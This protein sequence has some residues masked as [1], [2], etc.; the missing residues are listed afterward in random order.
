[1][2]PTPGANA[3]GASTREVKRAM[4]AIGLYGYLILPLALLV[5]GCAAASPAA[6]PTAAPVQKPPTAPTAKPAATAVP[7]PAATPVPLP[8]PQA[9]GNAA[10][11]WDESGRYFKGNPAAKVVLEEWTS[12]Q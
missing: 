11:Q 2:W 9:V 12:I 4:R 8:T 7:G 1:M 10:R 6:T 5:V 3:R